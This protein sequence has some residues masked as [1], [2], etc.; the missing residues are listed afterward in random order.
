MKNGKAGFYTKRIGIAVDGASTPLIVACIVPIRGGYGNH[1]E[2]AARA[3]STQQWNV[4]SRRVI[5]QGRTVAQP[6]SGALLVALREATVAK[7]RRASM[8]GLVQ[9]PPHRLGTIFI[10]ATSGYGWWSYSS[11][12]DF[13][14]QY[15]DVW[16][17][18][19]DVDYDTWSQLCDDYNAA[20]W[21]W[22]YS[23]DNAT[24]A[25]DEEIPLLE[26][27]A[28]AVLQAA[29]QLEQ[30]AYSCEVTGLK[31][32]CVDYFIAQCSVG[33]V[34][35]DCR[36]FDS[37]ATYA[38]SKLQIY[39]NPD[40]LT[41]E[42]KFNDTKIVVSGCGW[43]PGVCPPMI[44]SFGDSSHVVPGENVQV[45]AR[46][47]GSFDLV[48][49]VKNAGCAWA[50]FLCPAINHTIFFQRNPNAIGGFD[51]NWEGNTSPSIG[52]YAQNGST[53]NT[54]KEI[55]QKSRQAWGFIMGLIDALNYQKNL[56]PPDNP[57]NCYLT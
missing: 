36:G 27:M 13:L 56:P 20:Y 38:Q 23:R 54:M 44:F 11:L 24:A 17:G 47:D 3:V 39:I 18:E 14:S 7:P 49:N 22:Y 55:P 40:D 52:V 31:R 10:T 51:V 29:T 6:I 16:N 42:M 43:G 8:R 57:N 2:A 26:E 5:A 28:A 41:W 33:P 32:L 37:S 50:G 25:A 30:P 4:T 9:S 53:F 35:G 21:E 45:N 34:I 48:V 1:I 12:M 46:G 15:G 19:L